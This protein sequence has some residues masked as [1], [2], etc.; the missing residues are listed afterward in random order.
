MAWTSLGHSGP[1]QAVGCMPLCALYHFGGSQTTYD[2]PRCDPELAGGCFPHNPPCNPPPATRIRAKPESRTRGLERGEKARDLASAMVGEPISP[3][4]YT[5]SGNFSSKKGLWH[6]NI[7]HLMDF[8]T[9]LWHVEVRG[10]A[11]PNLAF[12]CRHTLPG[13]PY[14]PR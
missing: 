8:G 2:Y 3:N 12:G 10:P 13:T 5:C 1:K 7:T 14:S 4:I 6:H 11:G 9:C